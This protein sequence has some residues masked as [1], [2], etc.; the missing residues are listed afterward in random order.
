MAAIDDGEHIL[1]TREMVRE[2]KAFLRRELGNLKLEH[3]C[4]EGNFLMIRLGMSD[5]LAYRKLMTQGVMVRSM[6]GFRFPNYIRVTIAS[7]E[8]LQ[9]LVESLAAIAG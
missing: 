1:R 3:H 7:Q 9:A 2:G 5:S 4:A 6:T 8:A